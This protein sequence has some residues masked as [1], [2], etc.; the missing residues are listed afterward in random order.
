VNISPIFGLY[1]SGNRALEILL[2]EVRKRAPLLEVR[3]DLGIANQLRP[4]D[5]SAEMQEMR[6]ALEDARIL[7]ADGHHRYETALEYR[8]RRR[9]VDNPDELSGYDYVMMTLVAFD[10]P[11]LVILPTHRV[12]RGV[13]VDALGAFTR[14]VRDSFEAEEFDTAEVMQN[15]LISR[16]RGHLGVALRD[17]PVFRILRLK[18][19][20]AMAAALPSAPREVRE[21]DVSVLHAMIFD[22]MFALTPDEIRKGGNIEYT[23]DAQRALDSVATGDADGAFLMNPPTVEDVERVSASGA[24]MPEKSTYFYPKLLTGLVMNPLDDTP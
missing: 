21:L 16:G 8:R 18:N 14:G 23:V 17:D 9:S 6:R 12:L 1:P 10:D 24:V 22:R 11:G 13:T 20:Q 15:A 3:D 2:A 19:Q 4:I 5:A 7:I